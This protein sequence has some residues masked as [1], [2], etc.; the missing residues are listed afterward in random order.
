MIIS[1]AQ[2]IR[3]IHR[4]FNKMVDLDK[5][6]EL[7]IL[8]SW[9][10]V[11]TGRWVKEL[12]RCWADLKLMT[13]LTFVQPITNIH[14]YF[15]SRVAFNFAWHGVYCKMLLAL[16]PV[17]FAFILARVLGREPPGVIMF[18]SIVLMV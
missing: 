4:H 9:F 7:G 1:S 6:V 8:K 17:A 10:P 15:G 13:D 16:L 14:D 2:R 12:N 18:F 11:H 3:L 5:A